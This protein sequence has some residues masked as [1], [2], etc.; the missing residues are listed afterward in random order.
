MIISAADPLNLTGITTSPRIV[1]SH[2][3]LLVL[4]DGRVVASHQSGK[5]YFHEDMDGERADNIASRLSRLVVTR[6]AT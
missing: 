1:A 5:M 4:C 6:V 2:A 3:N